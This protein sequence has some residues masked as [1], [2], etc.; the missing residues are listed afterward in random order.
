MSPVPAVTVCAA[1]PLKPGSE[2][3]AVVAWNSPDGLPVL[4]VDPTVVAPAD[5][6]RVEAWAERE[7]A[8]GLRVS[9][10]LASKLDTI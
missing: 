2:L 4:R 1:K 5:Y 10:L 6:S 3:A 8:G 7:L 9:W